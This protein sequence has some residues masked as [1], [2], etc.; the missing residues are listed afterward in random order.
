MRKTLTLQLGDPR[1]PA[2]FWA[3]VAPNPATGCWEW[4]AAQKAG[5]G[6]YSHHGR[7]MA[8]H[9]VILGLVEELDPTLDVDH[10]CGVRHCV[11]PAH[12]RQVTR[13]ENNQNQG[14]ARSNSRSGVRG[15]RPYRGR[16]AAYYRPAG[17][18]KH[19]GVF[20]TKEEASEA[21]RTARLAAYS[22]NDIDRP[23]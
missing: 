16:W 5:Y 9:R 17:K 3:K 13:S 18:Y 8:A 7:V 11:N 15:V 19:I 21:A 2:R 23:N 12:L 10:K 1:L 22:H 14:P 6:A 4:T 20:G